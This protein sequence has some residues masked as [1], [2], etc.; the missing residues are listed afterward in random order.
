MTFS[1]ELLWLGDLAVDQLR[2]PLSGRVAGDYEK[3][4]M[5]FFGASFRWGQSDDE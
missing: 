3:A 4:A 2:G 1:Y 5:H